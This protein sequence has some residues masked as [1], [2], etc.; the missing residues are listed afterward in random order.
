MIIKSVD[1][2]DIGEEQFFDD[3]KKDMRINW[4][5]NDIEQ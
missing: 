1:E 4:K 5:Y 2:S 3:N